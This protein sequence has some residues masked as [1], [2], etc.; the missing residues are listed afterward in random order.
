MVF[1]Q[2]HNFFTSLWAIITL[3]DAGIKKGF[4]HIFIT[5]VMVSAAELVCIVDKTRCHVSE[6]SI[7]ISTVSLSLISHTIMISG[8]CLSAV[9]SQYAKV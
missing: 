5:L 1:L 9:L 3:N 2:E 4:T 7:A 8:S 6:A